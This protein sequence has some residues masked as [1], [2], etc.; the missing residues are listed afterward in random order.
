MKTQLIGISFVALMA[1]GIGY[2]VLGDGQTKATAKPAAAA[3]ADT[4]DHAHKEGDDHDH[5]H[6]ADAKPEAEGHGH[7]HEGEEEGEE[8]AVHLTEAQIVAAG[9]K[10]VAA[11]GGELATELRVSGTVTADA[12]RM[13]HVATRVPG[14]VAELRKRLGEQ[15]AAGEVLAVLDSAELAAAK[16]DFVAAGRRAALAASTQKREE[17]LWRK[18][19]SAEQEVL[20]ARAEAETARIALDAARQ[21]LASLG[22]GKGDIDALSGD[23]PRGLGRLELKAPIA[24]R[25]TV[26]DAVRGQ[27]LAADKEV[28]T[29]A[30]LSEVWVEIPVYGQDIAQV[31]EGQT[32][33]VTGPGGRRGQGTV[34][35]AGPTLDPQTGAARV[36]ARLPNGEGNWRPGDFVTGAIRAGG[37]PAEVLVPADAIQT[38]N[39]ENV[40]FVRTGEGFQA[41]AVELGR[42]NSRLV[43]VVFGLFPGEPVASGNSFVLKA[44]ASRGA[45]EH[46]HSH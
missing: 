31:R 10:V 7:D 34:I 32:V 40:V 2:A 9:V 15:V 37:Q 17:E 5:G 38:L 36:V 3:A 41:R 18:R 12:D 29:I 27:L 4:D 14:V 28:F 20:A 33:D 16:A 23:D 46:S 1:A 8:G 30:D 21:R 44:E 42:R 22:Q 45:A 25:V 6:A 39:G 19:I 35:F 11:E 13:V 26:R 43:E 24:G